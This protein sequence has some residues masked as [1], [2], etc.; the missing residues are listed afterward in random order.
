LKGRGAP[1]RNGGPA[2]DLLVE[3]KVSPHSLFT[4]EGNNL[5]TRVAVTFPEAVLGAEITVPALDGSS[6]RM[7]IV[8]GTQPG[9]RYRVKGRGITNGDVTGD[10]IAVVDVVV[11][12]TV[13]DAE[14]SAVEALARAMDT[15][16]G[17]A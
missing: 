10:L 17:G 8:A 9:K 6:V 16:R 2:G 7:R 15:A 12:T 11:P 1:G 3:C 14:R 4:R 13:T 5:V